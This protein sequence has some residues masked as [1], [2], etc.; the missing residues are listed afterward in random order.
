MRGLDEIIA[1]NAALD[2]IASKVVTERSKDRDILRA[3]T[4]CPGLDAVD[5]TTGQTF[6]AL[7]QTRIRPVGKGRR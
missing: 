4:R 1:D 5:P 7:L 3:M 2:A 6:R